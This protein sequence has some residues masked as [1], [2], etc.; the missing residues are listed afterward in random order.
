MNQNLD[1][2]D[3]H[4]PSG[5]ISKIKK[6]FRNPF[7]IKTQSV[8]E[9]TDFLKDAVDLNIIDKEAESIANKAIKLG[10][11]TVKE[12]MVPK[13]DMVTFGIDE[14]IN[15]IIEKIIESGHSRYPVLGKE[16]DEVSGL[17]LAKDMLPKIY[18]GNEDID[19]AEM[20]RE[21]NVVPETKKADSLLEEFKKDR[22]HLA[23]VIDEYGTISGL[24]TIEDILEE[25]VGEIED[26]HDIDEDEIVQ[27]SDKKYIAD[28]KVE[29]EE[30][31]EFFNLKTDPLE[32]DAE[33]LGG[34]V[35]T[36]LGVLPKKGDKVKIEN[37]SIKVI[38][39]DDRKID[40]VQ[41]TVT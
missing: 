31:T 37:L 36:Q 8:S 34:F 26:E 41:I 10:N 11:T 18:D 14:N 5:I 21:P 15:S 3:S 13:V 33:T 38:H 7:F 29:L 16:R 19:L 39:A 2:D 28:A 4:P 40:K 22:S 1:S 25:L 27:I 35:I 30:F 20:L 9:V 24:V 17:L 12:I 6:F 32:I 23:V